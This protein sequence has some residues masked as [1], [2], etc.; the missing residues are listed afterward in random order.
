MS[1]AV[2]DFKG[3]DDQQ[4]RIRIEDECLF[5]SK[6]Y[7]SGLY[8]VLSEYLP[9]QSFK[10][11]GDRDTG[12]VKIWA[13]DVPMDKE[14]LFHCDGGKDK[15]WF[16]QSIANM[17]LTPVPHCCG[18]LLGSGF[19][20][21]SKFNNQITVLDNMFEWFE[22]I[23]W[24]EFERSQVTYISTN[25][26]TSINEVLKARGYEKVYTFVNANTGNRVH[27]WFKDVEGDDLYDD[28]YDEY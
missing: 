3:K 6:F 1:S 26:Q 12:A 5:A 25:L 11:N 19:H 24:T 2:M 13:Y 9:I 21:T 7:C 28:D 8:K 17:T 20:A 14:G 18:L 27:S 23:S 15:V 10:C 22:E 16:E 4:I